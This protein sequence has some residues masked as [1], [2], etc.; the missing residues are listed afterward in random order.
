MSDQGACRGDFKRNEQIIMSRLDQAEKQSKGGAK[1]KGNMKDAVDST[2]QIRQWVSD[3]PF[4]KPGLWV[5]FPP[6]EVAGPSLG[7]VSS[8]L[9][10]TP[11]RPFA[12]TGV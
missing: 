1:K 7:V 5:G 11:V 9:A 4:R 6:V 8:Y 10:L 12:P 3:K 2:E